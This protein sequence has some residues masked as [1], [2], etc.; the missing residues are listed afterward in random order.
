MEELNCRGLACPRPVLQLKE[1]FEKGTPAAVSVI[2]D[3]E[4][5]KENVSRFLEH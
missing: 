4:A 5:A 2:V 1:M 3:N